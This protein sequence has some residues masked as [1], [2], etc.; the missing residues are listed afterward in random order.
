M[1]AP[2]LKPVTGGNLIAL[3]DDLQYD[4]HPPQPTYSFLASPRR[5][6]FPPRF[7]LV[8]TQVANGAV[9]KATV[10]INIWLWWA[11][12]VYICMFYGTSKEIAFP[13]TAVVVTDSLERCS[14]RSQYN[15]SQ[16]EAKAHR[17]K[18][19][20]NGVKWTFSHMQRATTLHW[21]RVTAFLMYRRSWWRWSR[22]NCQHSAGGEV[23]GW[24]LQ[25]GSRC[26]ARANVRLGR[27]W[28]STISTRGGTHRRGWEA[29]QQGS[30][31]SIAQMS[32]WWG[33][34]TWA[35][36]RL[37]GNSSTNVLSNRPAS[38]MQARKRGGRGTKGRGV[39]DQN[40]QW[41]EETSFDWKACDRS[42]FV[43]RNSPVV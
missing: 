36:R 33:L 7:A 43:L 19:D 20:Q 40:A 1:R 30:L 35:W 6:Q 39:V 11:I 17:L 8:L 37:H 10:V 27:T 29:T 12:F 21:L 4:T 2:I 38:A 26:G 22:I 23:I 5:P 41:K 18:S 3:F 28:E 24:S 9:V 15:Q 42:G 13:N 31:I 32:S 14:Y 25:S 16:H 34:I